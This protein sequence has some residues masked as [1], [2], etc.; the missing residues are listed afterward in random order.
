MRN[1]LVTITGLSF[2]MVFLWSVNSCKKDKMA[3]GTDKELFDLAEANSGFV[4][5]KNSDVLLDKSSGSGHSQPF[6]RTRYNAIAATQLDANGKVMAGA[7]F[8]EGSL[9][10]KELFDD[11]NTLSQYAILQKKSASEDADAEGWVWGYI[12][13]NGTVAEPA[14]N[15][16]K[17]CI[18]C[19]LQSDNIDYMLM[20]KYFP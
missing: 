7:S 8:P 3:E 14:S 20:N 9:V 4:W 1:K 10:V 15:K 13:A 12:N 11:A 19:H 6:L 17:A 16:G 5:Y 18:S 2:C